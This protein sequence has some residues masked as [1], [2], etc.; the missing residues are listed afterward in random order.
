MTRAKRS[1]AVRIRVVQSFNNMYR[2]DEAVV[3]HDDTVSGWIAAGRVRLVE[4]VHSGAGEAGQSG[5]PANDAG[6]ESEGTHGSGS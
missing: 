1:A 2:G 3:E 4:A 6:G 5:A